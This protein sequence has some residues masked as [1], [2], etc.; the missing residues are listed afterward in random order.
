MDKI[1]IFGHLVHIRIHSDTGCDEMLCCNCY[2]SS[3]EL[4]SSSQ[5]AQAIQ[6]NPHYT[7]IWDVFVDDISMFNDN[8]LPNLK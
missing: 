5:Y 3:I 7:N 8:F 1:N 2:D 6:N 4:L